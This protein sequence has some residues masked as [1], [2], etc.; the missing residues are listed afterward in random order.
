MFFDRS[1]Y[2]HLFLSFLVAKGFHYPL[3]AY[4]DFL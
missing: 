2:V 1:M 3:K 4:A